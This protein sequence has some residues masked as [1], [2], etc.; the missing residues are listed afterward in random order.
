[1]V[2]D[3]PNLH[4]FLVGKLQTIKEIQN[5]ETIIILDSPIRRE[6]QIGTVDG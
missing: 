1:V 6:V 3:V 4:A 5:A 2:A